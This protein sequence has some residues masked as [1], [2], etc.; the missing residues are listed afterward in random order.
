MIGLML[1]AAA[2][3]FET[4]AFESDFAVPGYV[5]QGSELAPS[6]REQVADSLNRSLIDEP[7]PL[8]FKKTP[9]YQGD[10]PLI[11]YLNERDDSWQLEIGDQ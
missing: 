3:Q 11:R 1:L 7:F 2:W 8:Q 4:P 5:E 9:R 6:V 10:S